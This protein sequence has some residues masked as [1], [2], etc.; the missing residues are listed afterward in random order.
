MFGFYTKQPSPMHV[1]GIQKVDLRTERHQYI[2]Y[3][4]IIHLFMYFGHW[5]YVIPRFDTMLINLGN[6]KEK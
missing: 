1:P 2:K 6:L 3:I 5:S 4:V